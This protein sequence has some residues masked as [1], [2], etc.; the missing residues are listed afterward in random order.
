M[1]E[2]I[3]KTPKGREGFN[4]TIRQLAQMLHENVRKLPRRSSRRLRRTTFFQTASRIKMVELSTRSS[5]ASSAGRSST[6]S[7]GRSLLEVNDNPSEG[8]TGAIL[9]RVFTS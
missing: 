3:D 8:W 6:Q 7:H 2:V 5:C 4:A 1:L 9:R